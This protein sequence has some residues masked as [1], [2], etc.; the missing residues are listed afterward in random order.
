VNYVQVSHLDLNRKKPYDDDTIF[1]LLLLYCKVI[2]LV[3]TPAVVTTEDVVCQRK[4][5]E[6]I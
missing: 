3:G 2:Q 4:F 6:N 5:S 1:Y